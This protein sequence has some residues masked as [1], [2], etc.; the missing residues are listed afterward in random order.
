MNDEHDQDLRALFAH[1]RRSDHADAPVW[2]DA[3]PNQPPQRPAVSRRWIPMALVTACVAVAAVF[4]IDSPPP[5]PSLSEVLPPLFNSPP[6]K[7]FASVEPS[8]T[9]F[10]APSDFLLPDHLNFHLP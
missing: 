2:R 5:E 6:G 8:F 4:L 10:E 9:A 1:Q 3:A 7:L